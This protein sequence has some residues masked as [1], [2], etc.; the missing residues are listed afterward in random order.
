MSKILQ[1]YFQW[2]L[3]KENVTCFGLHQCRSWRRSSIP[4]GLSLW[5]RPIQACSFSVEFVDFVECMFT[6][7]EIPVCLFM[8]LSSQ[9]LK[10]LQT[11]F[12][13]VNRGD[14]KTQLAGWYRT[15]QMGLYIPKVGQSMT[16]QSKESFSSW[17]ALRVHQTGVFW[18]ISFALVYRLGMDK[19]PTLCQLQTTKYCL[20]YL[21]S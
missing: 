5:G 2:V 8:E 10:V 9:Y 21:S 16:T 3:P 17:P 20:T 18:S 12:F 1:T 14:N 19:L 11:F 6:S 7:L 4:D 13:F 15:L